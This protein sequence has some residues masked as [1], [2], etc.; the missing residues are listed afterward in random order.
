MRRWLPLI[1]PF[2]HVSGY[3]EFGTN[4]RSPESVLRGGC[5][6]VADVV[7]LWR[8]CQNLLLLLLISGHLKLEL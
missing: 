8:E 6:G 7:A 4:W 5:K 2:C 1:V 3:F